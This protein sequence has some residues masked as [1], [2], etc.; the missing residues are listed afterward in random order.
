MGRPFSLQGNNAGQTARKTG[1][2]TK[3]T[4]GGGERGGGSWG[5]NFSESSAK[6]K[7]EPYS[8]SLYFS[9]T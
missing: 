8:S 6:S 9:S 2:M 7:S 4:V 3:H 5:T 1:F